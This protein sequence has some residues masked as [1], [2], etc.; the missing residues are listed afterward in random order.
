[1]KKCVVL[2]LL[3]LWFRGFGVLFN[4]VHAQCFE[5]ESILV[6]ACGSP[7]SNN[8]MLIFKVGNTPLNVNDMTVSWPN[9]PFL[10]ICQNA[11]T[12]NNVAW[13]NSTIQS[14]GYFLEPVNGVLPANKRVFLFT[15]TNI[16]QSAH[17]FP[18]LSDTVI[19]LFQCPGATSGHFAN[20]D[21]NPG[22]RTTI[23][24]FSQPSPCSDTVT[25]N[26]INLININGG[27]GGGS[28]LQN[29]A[30]VLFSPNGTPTYINPGCNP[31]YIPFTL[32][33][34][35]PPAT[36]CPGDF[37]NMSASATGQ[38]FSIQWSG[39]NGTF[40]GSGL[41]NPTYQVAQADA[42]GVT[43][44]VTATDLC[45]STLSQS[46]TIDVPVQQA[47][48]L[49]PSGQVQVCQGQSLTITAS[50]GGGS[51][52]WSSG[53]NTS[54]ITINA[55]GTY[56]VSSSDA[57]YAYSDSVIVSVIPTPALTLSPNG[58]QT[59]CQGN[60]LQL[61]AT[62]NVGTPQWSSG[63]TG[64]SI[65][66]NAAG[67]YIV[68]VSNSC[69]TA[70]DS[71][72][73]SIAT[74]PS[75]SVTP[76]A[77]IQI[78]NGQSQTITASGAQNYH[79]ST[80]T[81]AAS[82]TFSQTGNYWVVGSNSCGTDTIH[83][84]V[85]QGQAPVAEIAIQNGDS[86][87]CPGASIT[88]VSVNGS[89]SDQWSTG[90]VGTQTTI[91]TAPLTVT[92]TVSNACG[93][94]T[95]QISIVAGALPSASITTS[96]GGTT[97][98]SG[99]NLT[100]TASG[101]DNYSW[102]TGATGPTLTV[103]AG[104]TYTVTAS[105]ACGMDSETITITQQS[106]PVAQINP[107]GPIT[108]C[109]GDSVLL[110]GSGGDTYAWSTGETSSS[111]YIS[112]GGIYTLTAIN[113]CG[114]SQATLTATLQPLPEVNIIT[115][116]PVNLCQGSQVT[117]TATS[118]ETILWSNG[119]SG[120]SVTVS[121][122]GTLTASA[123]NACG[124]ATSTIVIN[125]TP[126]PQINIVQNSPLVSC[127]GTPVILDAVSNVPVQWSH[128]PTSASISVNQSGTYVVTASNACGTASDSVHVIISGPIASFTADPPTGNA[129][130][131]VLFTSTSTGA[132]NLHWD[133]DGT[134]YSVSSLNHTFYQ[135][136]TYEVL[137]IASD[138]NGCSDT[139]NIKIVVGDQFE[140]FV[141]NVFTPNGDGLNDIF[142]IMAT[143]VKDFRCRIFN[144]WGNEIFVWEDVTKGWD[145]SSLFGGRAPSGAYVYILEINSLSG[146]MKTLHGWVTLLD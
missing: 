130:L 20:Y 13:F 100:L 120:P 118:N 114:S 17:T 127:A 96:T 74:T 2:S 60:S 119:M 44:T 57:C 105:T 110:V 131:S 144:R 107:A 42:G 78:C 136:G 145:G 48:S 76:S 40:F 72:Q 28:A 93:S 50:G 54:Q 121:S 58:S 62:A 19:A 33:I 45:G 111:I 125:E 137:L 129:P 85:N 53:Q 108:F 6:D 113:G 103:S 67:T 23:I 49:S 83:I 34:N 51:Y 141:P 1:V 102:S 39:G 46:A 116:G 87:L 81:N 3:S 112:T 71:V 14:C 25:Y 132:T 7:E 8:E 126:L 15:S 140:V 59:L 41:L 92:L 84:T 99:S 97:L 135:P 101:G 104:G 10:G 73:V 80:G 12:A 26:K 98:C 115:Q 106:P 79:W 143:G 142:K 16:V 11:I 134:T 66:V 77:T 123:T 82:E 109:A 68:S 56:V 89:A 64:N 47:L 35:N 32:N 4:R 5:I 124:T 43:L 24:T 133:V 117:I 75:I 94:S 30:T 22:L 138:D 70:A 63:Q 128:G 86:V 18:N 55:A 122:G 139:A 37:L 9:N 90:T 52:T 38:I 65:S 61:T 27:Y 21:G 36:A 88:L 29:G 69:G 31:Q 91:N 95:D 146:E